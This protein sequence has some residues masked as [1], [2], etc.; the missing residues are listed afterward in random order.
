MTDD[1]MARLRADGQPLLGGKP[2]NTQ[3]IHAALDGL[4]RGRKIL[5]SKSASVVEAAKRGRSLRALARAIGLSP[6]YLSL[7]HTGKT[8][9]SPGA[10]R[11][12]LDQI[13]EIRR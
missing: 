2:M 5:Q 7:C 4:D 10:C 11:R 13:G 8:A 9:L 1:I 3:E 12:L 6:T